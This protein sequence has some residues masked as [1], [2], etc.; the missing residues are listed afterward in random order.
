M[1]AVGKATKRALAMN[2]PITTEGALWLCLLFYVL[3]F[4]VPLL[5]LGCFSLH[6]KL[7]R[8]IN[9]WEARRITWRLARIKAHAFGIVNCLFRIIT[10]SPRPLR[11]RARNPPGSYGSTGQADH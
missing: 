8:L 2:D 5:F 11:P 7:L 3:D 10:D 1:N 6:L 9:P 4:L